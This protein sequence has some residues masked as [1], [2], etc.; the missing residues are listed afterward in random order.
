MAVMIVSKEVGVLEDKKIEVGKEWKNYTL[1]FSKGEFANC[2]I[3]MFMQSKAVQ[4]DDIKVTSVQ[5]SIIPPVV[6]DAT[7]YTG[8]SFIAHWEPTEEAESYLFSL[9]KK[10]TAAAS[11]KQN[12]ETIKATANGLMDKTNSVIPEGWTIGLDRKSVV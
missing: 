6:L 5:T 11:V 2:A 12:F 4:I 3:E 1:T 10:E 8:D 9:Y 7:N